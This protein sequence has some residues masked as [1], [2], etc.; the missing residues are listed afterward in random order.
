MSPG[1][2]SGAG[3]QARIHWRHIA[4]A[5]GLTALLDAYLLAITAPE[6][7]R[8]AGAPIFDLRVG[9]YGHTEAARLLAAL[10][11]EGRRLYLVRHVPADT[12]LALIEAVAI[13]LI[14]LR[15]TRPGVRHAVAVP[16]AGR[17]ALLAVPLLTLFFDLGENTLVAHMLLTAAPEP[18][19]V[20]LAST[21]TQA[22]WVFA[23]LSIALAVVLPITALTRGLARSHAQPQQPPPS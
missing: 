5:L 19:T 21:L 10:G 4:L 6:L 14:L 2:P 11:S 12:V 8:I 23:S 7:A 15:A 20:A 9:G 16:S 22:K 13:M 17:G 18:P 1:R 3:A